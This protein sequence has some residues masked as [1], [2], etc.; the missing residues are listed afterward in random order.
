MTFNKNYLINF[1]FFIQIST[2][3]TS[4]DTALD[5]QVVYIEAADDDDEENNPQN[6]NPPA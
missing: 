6:N 2:I 5:G 4:I 3:L 1:A